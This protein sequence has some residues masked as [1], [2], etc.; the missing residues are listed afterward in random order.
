G[1]FDLG[2]Q[3]ASRSA[4]L[5]VLSQLPADQRPTAAQLDAVGQ[6]TWPTSTAFVP[7]GT[8]KVGLAFVTRLGPGESATFLV[9][10]LAHTATSGRVTAAALTDQATAGTTGVA[11]NL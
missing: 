5:D 3:S 6:L 1:S 11:T 8:E 4:V 7:D 10:T 9:S 2:D